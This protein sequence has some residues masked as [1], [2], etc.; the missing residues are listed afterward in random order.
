MIISHTHKFI[1][2]K[3]RK[4]ASTSMQLALKQ[5]CS[6]SDIIS[7]LTDDD[8]HTMQGQNSNGFF[9]HM[10]A[11]KV[12]EAVSPDIWNSYFKF[13]FDRNPWDK[14]ISHYYSVYKQ[15]PYR[16]MS[17]N[18][19]IMHGTFHHFSD[20]KL[21]SDENRDKIIIDKIFKYEE[22]E[23]AFRYIESKLKIPIKIVMPDKK[24][25]S[26]FR[27]D[28]RPYQDV[29]TKQERDQIAKIFHKEIKAFNYKF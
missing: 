3:V 18:S 15:G 24:F 11:F 4:T 10:P 22:R 21:Y 7:N 20:W 28:H 27:K 23:D 14:T 9:N 26:H 5:L 6:P 19:F 1:F 8:N 2:I 25:K 16:D 29:L 12:Q 13:A 17:L